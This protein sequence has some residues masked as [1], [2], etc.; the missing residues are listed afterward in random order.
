ME[1]TGDAERRRGVRGEGE[2]IEYIGEVPRE[3]SGIG[4]RETEP[5]GDLRTDSGGLIGIIDLR[6][7]VLGELAA[8]DDRRLES[9]RRTGEL[10][11]ETGLTAED[12]SLRG[13]DGTGSAVRDL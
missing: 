8:L 10:T 13:A 5:A 12:L 3:I 11:G 1:R 9:G 2:G 4:K 7:G 6:G